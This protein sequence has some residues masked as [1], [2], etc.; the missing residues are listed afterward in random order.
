MDRQASRP[1]AYVYPSWGY[2]GLPVFWVTEGHFH[3]GWHYSSNYEEHPRRRYYSGYPYY[4]PYRDYRGD[5]NDRARLSDR[6]VRRVELPR[7]SEDRGDRYARPAGFRE[8]P[9]DR[10]SR[11]GDSRNNNPDIRQRTRD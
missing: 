6:P 2:R 11:Y 8:T 5:R 1:T 4:A 7:E 3:D 10:G 9:V